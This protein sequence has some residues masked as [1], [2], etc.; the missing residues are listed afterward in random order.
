MAG[1]TTPNVLGDLC[2]KM[3]EWNLLSFLSMMDDSIWMII[4][5]L[6]KFDQ[7]HNRHL[8]ART[9]SKFQA[10]QPLPDLMMTAR[11][12]GEKGLLISR[13]GNVIKEGGSI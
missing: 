4:V 5:H 6:L 3:L 12:G 13:C 7:K 8:P 1:H 10:I 9:E 11:K 2:W